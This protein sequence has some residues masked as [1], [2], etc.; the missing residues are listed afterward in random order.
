MPETNTMGSEAAQEGSPHVSDSRLERVLRASHFAVCGELGPPQ[1]ASA[2][3]IVRKS[4]HFRGYADAVNLTDNQ[5]AVVRMSSIAAAKLCIDQGLE[6]VIQMTC[7]DRNRI[8]IQSDILG[9]AALGIR[10]VLCLSGDHQSMGNH[11]QA[12]CVHDLDSIQLVG[13]LRRMRD[14]S[15]FICGDE[16]K[17]PARMFIAAACNPFGDPYE[18]RVHRLAKKVAVGADFI[19]TQAIYD[20]GKFRHFMGLVRDRG[21][22]QRVF[23][24][25]GILPVKSAKALVF[26]RNN[27][28]GMSIPDDL[29]DR[30]KGAENPEE[31][32]IKLAI[33]QVQELRQIEGVAGVH[34]MPALWEAAFPRIVEGAGLLPRPEVA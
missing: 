30:M 11:P 17:N 24:L 3:V 32:G 1:S 13:A 20:M 26:M 10:N 14:E 22:H 9:A 21:L 8:A 12:K 34:I 33:E 6:P 19:Q 7:R 28:A 15:V 29:I 16:T 4:Q 31:E 5:T 27:V 18:A 25:A 2:D 23:I